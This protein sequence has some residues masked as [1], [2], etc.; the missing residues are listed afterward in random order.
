M[1]PGALLK[2]GQRVKGALD[3]Y[4][5][6]KQLSDFVYL[7]AG[8][9]IE[10]Y[11]ISP[12]PVVHSLSNPDSRMN[13]RKSVVLKS[14]DGHWRLHNEYDVLRQLQSTVPQLRSPADEIKDDDI[15][16]TI[17]LS[18][19]DDDL[20]QASKKQRLTRREINN[21]ATR[22][23]SVQLADIGGT[24]KT[25][26]M[27]ATDGHPTGTNLFRAPEVHLGLPWGTAADIWSFGTTL[28]NLIWSLNFHIFEPQ[29]PPTDDM[30]DIMV[31]V[32]QHRHFGPFPE[33]YKEFTDEE[34]QR[35]ILHL[36]S[37]VPPEKM[38]PFHRVGE[39][40]IAPADKAFLLKIMK[41]DPR[42]RTT[43]HALL[44]DEW[45]AETSERTVGWYSKAQWEKLHSQ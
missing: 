38:R 13:S 24:V 37:W 27:Y 6:T 28:M 45:W 10:S 1:S 9:V 29:E 23:S 20:Y 21:G 17:A 3:V 39:R 2:L 14:I 22:F 44:E 42:E 12:S 5:I 7:A 11:N 32:E 30:Y 35:A 40:E 31:L 43:A 18:Y 33:T 15:T 26:S 34:T 41:L 36:M 8:W 16:P 25:D 19:L 4:T